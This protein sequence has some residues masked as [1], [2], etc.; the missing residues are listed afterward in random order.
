MISPYYVFP[1]ALDKSA[2]DSVLS[3]CLD[4]HKA[5][6]QEGVLSGGKSNNDIRR[7]KITWINNDKIHDNI[8][9]YAKIANSAAF[10]F[11][12]FDTINNVQFTEYSAEYEGTYNWHMDSWFRDNS[13]EYNTMNQRKLSVIVQLSSPN[14]YSGGEFL[15]KTGTEELN[16]PSIREKGTIIVFPSFILHKVNPVTSGIRHSLVSW[17][18]GPAFR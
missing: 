5:N 15:F 7:S 18:L 16:D 11:D 3:H 6:Q 13:S 1:N 4:V 8:S 12:L 2:C 10:G 17:I 14:D 9:K